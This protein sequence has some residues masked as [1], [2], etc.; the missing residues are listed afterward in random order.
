MQ[1]FYGVAGERRIDERTIGWLPGYEGS[2]PVR[3]GNAAVSQLQLDV[4][5]ELLDVLY[6]ARSAGL[7]A[8]DDAWSVQRACLDWLESCWEQPDEGMWEIRSARRHFTFSKV[9]VWAA[10]DR[11]VKTVEQLGGDGPV[12]RWRAMRARV[13][14]QVCTRGFDRDRNTFTQVYGRRELDASLLL[15][16]IVGFLPAEDPRVLG[17]IDAVQRELVS[18]GFVR[19]Y[20]TQERDNLDGLSGCEGVFLAC[21]FWLVDALV[22]VGR[23]DEAAAL[24]ERLLA[25]R[26]D[27]GLLSEEYD[28]RQRRLVGNFPQA[29]SH[30]ALINSAHNL[31]VPHGPAHQRARRAG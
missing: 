15:V 13:H 21:S 24:F 3:V 29:F 7:N 6:I 16:P 28:P 8:N 27:V 2:R 4:Y 26:N 9:M 5:G 22:L 17:T 14:D 30:V 12:D 1:I 10:F 20:P 11:A 19:R 18:D 31:C 23:R 25:V